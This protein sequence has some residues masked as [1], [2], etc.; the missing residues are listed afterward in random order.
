MKGIY[1]NVTVLPYFFDIFI[2]NE[3]YKQKPAVYKNMYLCLFF[4]I[5]VKHKVLRY[6]IHDFYADLSLDG[7]VFRRWLFLLNLCLATPKLH[8]AQRF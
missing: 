1:S 5:N 8:L 7:S 2:E 6:S 4:M 3:L